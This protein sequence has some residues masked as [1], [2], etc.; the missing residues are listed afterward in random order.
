MMSDRNVTDPDVSRGIVLFH[1]TS[2]ENFLSIVSSR[3]IWASDIRYM[4][5]S[6]EYTFAYKVAEEV[7]PHGDIDPVVKALVA[8]LETESL[9]VVSLTEKGDDIGQWRGYTS[10]GDGISFAFS[11]FF[12][13][14]R[15]KSV[16]ASLAKCTYDQ[17][18]Q[19]EHVA[20]LLRT[21][22][23]SIRDHGMAHDK[24]QEIGKTFWTHFGARMK[25]PAFEQEDEW[26]ITSNRRASKSFRA[27]RSMIIPFA[28]LSLLD[29]IP[30]EFEEII[31]GPTP[32]MDLSL[33]SLE[34]FLT[35]NNL[36]CKSLRPSAIPFR[37]W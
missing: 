29:V 4:N 32:N 5:D 31:I 25:H 14:E 34:R 21:L 13:E 30:L 33:T 3:N 9:Y 28:P 22:T 11:H 12:L 1:Y 7:I 10:A 20:N 6:E 15:C 18:Q 23:T 2:L 19:R 16:C 17:K 26:R 27:G 36:L 37:P 8:A 24:V 35:A